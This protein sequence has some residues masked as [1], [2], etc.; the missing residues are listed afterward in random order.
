MTTDRVP[1]CSKIVNE[2]NERG[3]SMKL[4]HDLT[5]NPPFGLP[6]RSAR[7][8]VAAAAIAAVAQAALAGRT[9]NPVLPLW[10]HVP[11]PEP[12][13][14]D[15][16]LY[17]YGS[18]DLPGGWEFCLDDYVV[19]SAPLADLSDWRCEGVSFRKTDDPENPDG[20]DVL[21]APDVVR[22]LDGRYYLYYQRNESN[23]GN[24]APLGVALSEKPSGPFKF[25]GYVHHADGT[26]YN[27]KKGDCAFDPSVL[28]DG[29]RVWLYTGFASSGARVCELKPDMLTICSEAKTIVPHRSQTS[30][31]SFAGHGFFEASSARKIDGKYFF[32]YSSEKM[33]ELC[34]ATS[35]APDGPFVFRGVLVDNGFGNNQGG[36]VE[37]GGEWYIFYHRHTYAGMF[38][39][40]CCVERLTRLPDGGFAKAECTSQGLGGPLPATGCYPAA[41]TCDIRDR[42]K[43]CVMQVGEGKDAAV[44]VQI[45]K[46]GAVLGFRNF[47]FKDVKTLGVE[48]RGWTTGTVE[49]RTDPNGPVLGRITTQR[50]K[51][52]HFSRGEVNLP[53]GVHPLYLTLNWKCVCGPAHLR[54]IEFASDTRRERSECR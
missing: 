20:N 38:S 12:R 3:Q 24:A 7:R 45:S 2:N 13:V 40:Q 6:T 32:V 41:I 31:T 25:L 30:G 18:R 27:A 21:Y 54:A 14:Y 23:D 37:I 36:L 28:I 15:G 8:F 33:T 43:A 4:S 10:E 11:D 48:M 51:D 5:T 29:G 42:G 49:V 50:G 16:R 44:F 19:W 46:T 39:R 47:N 1:D 35:D 17:I 34:Y 52:W 9:V 26:R 53:D 22:G